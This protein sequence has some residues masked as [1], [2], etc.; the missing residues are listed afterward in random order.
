MD[1]PASI[2]FFTCANAAYHDY[3]PLYA[4]SVLSS[5]PTARVE[6]GVEGEP[7]F[8]AAHGSAFEVLR[9]HFGADRISAHAVPWLQADGR[10]VL[11]NTV[12][13]ITPPRGRADYVY[14]GDI[15]IIFLDR[16]FPRPH[17]EF[18]A[19]TGLPYSNSVRPGTRRMS[20]LHFSRYDA[21]YPIPSLEGLD[22]ARDN[23]E[24]VLYQL[25]RR[26]GLMIQDAEWFRPT[27]GIHASPNRSI[28]RR[29]GQPGWGVKAHLGAYQALIRTDAVRALR[30]HLSPRVRG[31][32][33]TIEREFGLAAPA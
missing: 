33:E 4:C 26:R 1:D 21:Y 18:M 8:E 9:A 23:D 22:L 17:L 6:L 31:L 25:C 16:S 14:I 15:D 10:R 11:P 30:P 32:L 13:F 7:A 5:A 24:E 27:H 29:D 28:R 2:L 20:G 19:R 3:A 12:R